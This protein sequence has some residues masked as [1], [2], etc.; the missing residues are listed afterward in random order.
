MID[1]P[2]ILTGAYAACSASLS[3]IMARVSPTIGPRL[4]NL[5]AGAAPMGLIF[6]YLLEGGDTVILNGSD[7]LM[8]G[9]L[10]AAGLTSAV[11]AGRL[12]GKPERKAL[13]A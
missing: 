8:A 10:F 13:R 11:V 6:A 5:F 9:G 3:A 7:L 1:D 2:I 12:S 4:R